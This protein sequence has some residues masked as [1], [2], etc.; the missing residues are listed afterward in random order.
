MKKTWNPAQDVEAFKREINKTPYYKTISMELVELNEK[1]AVMRIRSGPK[2]INPFGTIHGGALASV[3]DAAC[4]I[5]VMYHMKNEE[6]AI[7]ISLNVDFV[8][9]VITGDIAAHAR[10]VH[11]G[12]RLARAEAVLTDA[13]GKLIAKGQASFILDKK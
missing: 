11:R 8:A 2:H 4:G 10:M 9:P 7:T 3:I 12:R 6:A 13:Q 1:E 5:S